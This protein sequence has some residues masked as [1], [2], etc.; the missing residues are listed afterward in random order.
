MWN[1]LILHANDLKISRQEK[2]LDGFAAD[3]DDLPVHGTTSENKAMAEMMAAQAERFVNLVG[4]LDQ[5]D[6]D[7]RVHRLGIR[8]TKVLEI[9]NSFA[10]RLSEPARQQLSEKITSVLSGLVPD[11]PI[12]T[13]L[14]ALQSTLAGSHDSPSSQ[15]AVI[16][17]EQASIVPRANANNGVNTLMHSIRNPRGSIHELATNMTRLAQLLPL[18]DQNQPTSLPFLADKIRPGVLS[19]DRPF[20]FL[21]HHLDTPANRLN[22]EQRKVGR[23]SSI[24]KRTVEFDRD[25]IIRRIAVA[26]VWEE[27]LGHASILTPKQQGRLL[28]R[29]TENFRIYD[30][31][32]NEDTDTWAQQWKESLAA[33]T[34][35]LARLVEVFPDLDSSKKPDSMSPMQLNAVAM[36]RTY[37]PQ[38]SSE[39]KTAL[40]DKIGEVA[41]ARP[42]LEENHQPGMI[43]LRRLQ[44]ELQAIFDN[45]P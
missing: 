24:P 12:S 20:K 10:V 41:A 45:T 7:S 17:A 37:G 34:P 22:I 2:M 1:E 26:P 4:M 23:L 35:S 32:S 43:S 8:E 3:F 15:S 18:V 6:R 28:E 42:D 33:Y 5:S 31:L 11:S 13:H 21:I 9:L 25:H 30:G 38:L 14:H 27:L 16:Q 40:K 19:W 36:L 29:L 39:A 44:S